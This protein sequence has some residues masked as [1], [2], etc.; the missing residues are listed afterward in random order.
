MEL[1]KQVVN[2]FKPGKLMVTFYATRVGLRLVLSVLSDL[3]NVE[4]LIR[5]PRPS[6]SMKN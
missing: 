5:R 4:T 3:F 2:T 6:A 1:I